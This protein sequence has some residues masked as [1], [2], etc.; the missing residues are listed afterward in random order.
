MMP[1]E[2]GA[3]LSNVQEDDCSGMDRVKLCSL[4]IIISVMRMMIFYKH[5]QT[6]AGM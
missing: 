1:W 2:D 5:Q 3:H 4:W 6:T